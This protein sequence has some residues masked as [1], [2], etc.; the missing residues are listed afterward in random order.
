MRKRSISALLLSMV[1]ISGFVCFKPNSAKAITDFDVDV[2]PQLIG[3]VANFQFVYRVEADLPYHARIE[4]KFPP[5]TSFDPPIPTEEKAR[6]ERLRKI[7][8]NMLF[9]SCEIM[10]LPI[11]NFLQDGSVSIL[12]R[13]STNKREAGEKVILKIKKEAGIVNPS[14]PGSYHYYIRTENEEDFFES[15]PVM[16]YEDTL[17]TPIVKLTNP[18]AGETTGFEINFTL[19]PADTLHFWVNSF[20]IEFPKTFIFYMQ[21]SDMDKNMNNMI[22]INDVPLIYSPGVME[23]E[24]SNI[25][26]LEL[27][28]LKSTKPYENMKITI[29]ERFGI[30]N[31]FKPGAYTIGVWT[32]SLPKVVESKPFHINPSSEEALATL[33]HNVTNETTNVDIV[34]N[35]TE[36]LE[37]M[38]EIQVVFPKEFEI[39]TD[40]ITCYFYAPNRV[41]IDVAVFENVM[42]IPVPVN[43]QK[44]ETIRLLYTYTNDIK[45]PTIPGSYS[46]LIKHPKSG[47]SYQTNPLLIEDQALEIIDVRPSVPNAYAVT[48]YYII[49]LAF[50]SDRIPRTGEKLFFTFEFIDQ[51]IQYEFKKNA[52]PFETVVLKNIKNPEP[53]NYSISAQFGNEKA[54]Y[55]VKINIIP[56][57]PQTKIQI[58][59]GKEGN[60]GWFTELPKIS[61]LFDDPD[62]IMEYKVEGYDPITEKSGC[63]DSDPLLPGQYV[64]LITYYSYCAYGWENSKEFLLKVDTI[65]PLVNIRHPSKKKTEQNINTI[66]VDGKISPLKLNHYAGNKLVLDT[67]LTINGIISKV[68]DD[69]SFSSELSLHEGNN[70]IQVKVMDEAG[71]SVQ[72]DYD[73][74]VDTLSP[75]LIVNTPLEGEVFLSNTITIKG[76]TEPG[77]LLFMNGEAILL[78]E[79]GSFAV[80]LS[81][82]SLGKKEIKIT[83]TDKLNNQT[84]QVFSCWFGYTLQ[85]KIGDNQAFINDRPVTL[86]SPPIIDQG[87]T[88]VPFRFIGE[89]IGIEV[90]Y[91]TDPKTKVVSKVFYISKTKRIEL[92]IG[93][94]VA[95]VNG[96]SVAMDVPP[97]ILHGT[98]LVPLRFVAEKLDF[99]VQWEVDTQTITL[100]YPKL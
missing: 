22:F 12:I 42:T 1:F 19:G 31:P 13:D 85:L 28:V 45:T 34:Y 56:P 91:Q 86:L 92:T 71:N 49:D 67:N 35:T 59:G 33:P 57:L 65:P 68:R 51:P 23:Y 50:H 97:R 83:A 6:I 88:L 55:P 40:E 64:S 39:S 90:G 26:A 63:D 4:L 66:L 70:T 21:L 76:I 72:Y 36:N 15:Q 20:I 60:N 43:V 3:E 80:E 82:D 77:A 18:V 11:I 47:K 98:T 37:M 8:E 2:T 46:F 41:P 16:I 74:L 14:S 30:R 96:K 89:A 7:S 78:E 48:E 44:G 25:I 54:V 38:D 79:D 5:G 61:F 29:D 24:S 27:P 9:F 75:S 53:G 62:S 93:S 87:R 94:K 69:G 81:F 17:S 32:T 58:E 100:R 95:L 99:D 84:V 10:G 73:V 52:E